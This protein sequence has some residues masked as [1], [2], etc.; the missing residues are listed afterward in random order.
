MNVTILHNY[1]DDIDTLHHYDTPASFSCMVRSTFYLKEKLFHQNLSVA[2]TKD[3][4]K[5]TESN[6][7]L[8]YNNCIQLLVTPVAYSWFYEKLIF[9]EMVIITETKNT[10]QKA[11]CK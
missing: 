8:N 5:D 3:N 6:T 9:F 1:I 4:T 11:Q 7:R 2:A 10:I